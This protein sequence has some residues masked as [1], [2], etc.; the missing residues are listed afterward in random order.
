MR[1]Y[2]PYLQEQYMYNLNEE[3][4]KRDFLKQL[5]DLVIQKQ[6]I[7]I[8]LLDWQE[9]PI[10]EIQGELI[11]GSLSK[12]SNNCVRTVGSLSCS[13]SAGTYS[14]D[15]LNSNFAL[16]KKIF[17]EIG[18]RN[19]TNMY[20]DW[21]ILWFPQG[22]FLITDF[23]L[24]SSSTSAVNL[25]ISIKDKMCLLNGDVGG[26]LPSYVQ[27]D[28]MDTQAPDGTFIEH[29]QKVLIYDI[30]LELLNH[31]GGEDLN[32]IIIQD[33][34]LR[35]RQVMKWNGSN[36]LYGEYKVNNT[37]DEEQSDFSEEEWTFTLDKPPNLEN[38]IEYE[39]NADVGYI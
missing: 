38:V 35:I 20:T 5:D 31:F 8:T 29:K 34:P 6:Y 9:N 27:F 22:V 12:D 25:N 16:N 24:N 21:P 23:A 14:I 37:S 10:K 39:Q 2:Y 19:D 3:Q 17:I 26:K 15:S 1:K 32:N 11:G 18:I 7:Q 4:N 33:V 36:K 28:V 30:L 13:V